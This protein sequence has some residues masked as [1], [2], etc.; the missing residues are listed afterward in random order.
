MHKLSEKLDQG[1]ILGQ[2]IF[3][4]HPQEEVYD[5]YVRSLEYGLILLKD[6][7]HKI[8]DISPTP[9]NHLEATFFSSKDIHLLGERESFFR[10]KQKCHELKLND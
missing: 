1:D 2:V 4:I 10:S 3:T 9:Q 7:L 5:I 8:N 6:T